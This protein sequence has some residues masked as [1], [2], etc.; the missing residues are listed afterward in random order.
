MEYVE[1]YDK[2][3]KYDIKNDNKTDDKLDNENDTDDVDYEKKRTD[4]LDYLYTIFNDLHNDIKYK[5][6]VSFLKYDKY[7]DFIDLIDNE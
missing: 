7:R 4:Y 6:P 3:D 2:Y 5:F 1:D